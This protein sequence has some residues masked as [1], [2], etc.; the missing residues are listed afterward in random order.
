MISSRRREV[1]GVGGD[2]VD[3]LRK[4][5]DASGIPFGRRSILLDDDRRLFDLTAEVFDEE[6]F[7]TVARLD[8]L[9]AGYTTDAVVLR[10]GRQAI[11]WG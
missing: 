1:L 9:S 10:L 4:L 8:R 2:S 5:R 6:K 11:T 7:V 3:P